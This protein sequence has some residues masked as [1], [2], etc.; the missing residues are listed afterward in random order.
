MCSID[1]LVSSSEI[2]D[3]VM[4]PLMRAEEPVTLESAK[5][6]IYNAVESPVPDMDAAAEKLVNGFCLVLFGEDQAAAFEVKTG[7][8]RSVSAPEVENTIKGAKDAFTETVRT[9]TSLVRRHL[10]TPELRLE[11]Q[12]IGDGA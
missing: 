9:N 3:F 7:E 11:E 5:T 6:L 4:K 8:K 1:G 10:R 12:V 2:S